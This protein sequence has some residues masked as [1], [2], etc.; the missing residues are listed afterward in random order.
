MTIPLA[1]LGS[2]DAVLRDS[3]TW[4]LV[5]DRPGTAVLRHDFGSGNQTGW[6]RRHVVDHT[7]VIEDVW[8]DLEGR[9]PSCS[10]RHDAIE[11]LERLVE[12]DR[13]AGLLW[14][15]PVGVETLPACQSVEAAVE[16]GS[17]LSATHLAGV[18]ATVDL[19]T[20]VD[21]ILGEELLADR[22]LGFP[23]GEERSVGEVLAA[24]IG[25]ADVV[26]TS[27]ADPTGSDLV[28]HLRPLDGL[29]CDGL[30]ADGHLL[31]MDQRHDCRVGEHRLDPAHVEPLGGPAD[32]GVW[33]L[34]LVSDRPFHPDRLLA[35]IEQLGAG[36]LR[37]R[38]RFWVPH[39]AEQLCQWD[40][41]GGQVSIGRL[42][43]WQ[44][45]PSTRLV[46]TGIDDDR[47]RITA[48]F[49]DSLLTDDEWASGLQC[50]IGRESALDA[51][52]E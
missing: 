24:Q 46:I 20:A 10:F 47:E 14:G 23:G 12:A 3:L 37:S 2:V 50:W 43:P 4:N 36:R 35:N 19:T 45:G 22:A 29:R 33:T 1:L 49:A 21:D 26:V 8:I 15:L 5:H 42:G 34:D 13:W 38:G 41:A 32:N 7:G 17:V 9:C 51:W 27:G 30:H 28:E 6:L 39:R 44:T 16:Q 40:G 52:L 25:H 11:A 18:G 31:L 48:A